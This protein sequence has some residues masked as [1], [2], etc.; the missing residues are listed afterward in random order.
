MSEAKACGVC[1]AGRSERPG[2]ALLTVQTEGGDVG[3]CATC[4]RQGGLY[5]VQCV[6]ADGQVY[7][8]ESHVGP[9][10]MAWMTQGEAESVR[11]ELEMDAQGGERYVVAEVS[12]SDIERAIV[13]AEAVRS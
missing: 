5:V 6:L 9:E 7:G 2:V 13:N 1:V 4:A 12:S 11:D 3:L 10:G 8:D